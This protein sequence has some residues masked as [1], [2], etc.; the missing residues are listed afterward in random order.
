LPERVQSLDQRTGQP[1]S[2]RQGAV[3]APPLWTPTTS[4]PI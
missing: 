4:S 2:R 1:D 3:G